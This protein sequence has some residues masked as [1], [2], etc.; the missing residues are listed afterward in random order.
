M[1]KPVFQFR[2]R[3]DSSTYYYVDSSR[4]VVTSPTPINIKKGVVDWNKLQILY[5]RHNVYVGVF[6]HYAPEAA[7]FA[8][9]AAQI[10][11]YLF[12][13]Q[14]GTEAVCELEVYKLNDATQDY[15]PRCLCTVNFS[16]HNNTKNYVSEALMEG[17]LSAKLNSYDTTDFEIPL[18]VP[19]DDTDTQWLWVSGNP[20]GSDPGGVTLLGQYNYQTQQDGAALI[21][22]SA[23]SVGGTQQEMT[24]GVVFINE[25]GAYSVITPTSPLMGINV[26]AGIFENAIMS[27]SVQ[28]FSGVL[29]F[30]DINFG[31]IMNLG[32]SDQNIEVSLHAK[33]Y[34]GGF[35]T[36]VSDTPLWT[37]PAGAIAPGGSSPTTTATIAPTSLTFNAGDALV[38]VFRATTSAAETG[39]NHS[40][41][42]IKLGSVASAIRLSF[43][44]RQPDTPCRVLSHYNLFKQLFYKITGSTS[45]D[46]VSDL[47]TTDTFPGPDVYNLNNLYTF[48]TSGDALRQLYVSADGTTIDPVIK[49]NFAD[50][51][52]DAFSRCAAG[53]GIEK[54]DDGN[55]VLRLEDLGYFYQK[56]VLIAHLGDRIANWKMYAYADYKA[57]S[58]KSGYHDQSYD[59]VNG[60]YEYNSEVTHKTPVKSLN[61]DIDY[62]APLRTD[63]YGIEYTRANL[64]NKQTTD[65]GSDNDTFIIQSNGDRMEID[66][67]TP[68]PYQVEKAQTVTAGLP[69]SVW[70]TVYNMP[71]S[72]ARCIGR[73]MKWL[74]SVY[75][76][77]LSPGLEFT[78][79]TK[80]A[81]VVSSMYTGPTVTE[82]ADVDLAPDGTG[83]DILFKPLVFEFDAQVPL[84]LPDL[85]A[86]NPYGVFRHTYQGIEL[87]GFV[88]EAGIKDG[89]NDVFTFKL[90]CS[91]DTVIPDYL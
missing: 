64:A 90:L 66:G 31:H 38:L 53:I 39:V 83:E 26:P 88:L 55:E 41:L 67:I 71:F 10:L 80:N 56:D 20:P 50:F 5:R 78:S 74:R 16:Q 40:D 89:V 32:G 51:A 8:N 25:E 91:P 36:L 69:A 59:E 9:D 46:P 62:T 14:G 42:D 24:M 21:S 45:V 76:D 1:G 15:E 87:D 13:R 68:N 33:I 79:A 37:D 19:D 27:K 2:F 48:F 61:K 11:R 43:E 6:R 35:G 7:R 47:L 57:N 70:P 23:G 18:E 77:M 52:K 29:T 86:T 17:G 3:K 60:R 63:C 58:I 44:F 28:P 49:I 54:D 72:P 12:N 84:D 73:L 75:G 85:M 30:D 4:A 82:N 34:N 81:D 22:V 65:S